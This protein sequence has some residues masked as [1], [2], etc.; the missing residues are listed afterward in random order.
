MVLGHVLLKKVVCVKS[1]PTLQLWLERGV[2]VILTELLCVSPLVLKK[3]SSFK[4][5]SGIN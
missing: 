5:D 4:G 3:M 1:T 2:G